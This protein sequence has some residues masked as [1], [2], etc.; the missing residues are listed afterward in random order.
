[1]KYTLFISDL[2][3]Q[4]KRPE[5]LS[6]FEFFVEK[7]IEAADALYILGDFFA[8]W[9]GDDDRS[10]FNE[11]VK[12]I[13]RS[14]AG[15]NIPVYLLPGNHD[16]MLGN[17]FAASSK[18]TLLPDPYCINLYG[19]P[20]LLT[21][22]DLLCTKDWTMILFHDFIHSRWCK[23]LF[24]ILP[25]ILRKRIANFIEN[26]I[27]NSKK[28]GRKS[29]EVMRVQQDA[30]EKMMLKYEVG[31]LIH[32]HTHQQAI[33]EFAL[34]ASNFLARRISLGGWFEGKTAALFYW[35]DGSCEFKKLF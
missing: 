12:T 26:Y 21:H 35:E 28:Q 9:V 23:F 27:E 24:S 34:G 32:G 6:D 13:L 16:F 19:K 20:T 15:Y 3:L 7:Y 33:N 18:C 10:E 4:E 14:V 1:M 2:H 8:Q 29:Q 31:L 30:I 17:D 11:K 5:V 22:G 25:V